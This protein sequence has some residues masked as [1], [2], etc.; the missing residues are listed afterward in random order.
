MK[1]IWQPLVG[2]FMILLGIF[3]ATLEILPGNTSDLV[4]LLIFVLFLGLMI[5]G[6][7]M[8]IKGLKRK[9][10]KRASK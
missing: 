8:L 3:L 2:I 7:T 1:K 6:S 5:G 9:K 10:D 4:I